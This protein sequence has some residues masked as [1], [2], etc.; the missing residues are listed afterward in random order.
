M[1]TAVFFVLVKVD[2]NIFCVLFHSERD[3]EMELEKAR[4]THFEGGSM[5]PNGFGFHN[6]DRIQALSTNS[7]NAAYQASPTSSSMSPASSIPLS[8][9]S[10]V[11]SP[12][13]AT[14]VSNP[15][16]ER[17]KQ[18]QREAER[19]R[20]AATAGRIDL[21]HQHDLMSTFEHQMY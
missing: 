18:R 21:T 7:P 1:V 15:Q 8:P 5:P 9:A 13:E 4:R 11:A 17:D 16:S 19:R 10:Q 3:Q 20:R 2:V 6:R 12:P 14:G